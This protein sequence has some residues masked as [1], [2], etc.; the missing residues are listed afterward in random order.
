ME[1]VN[2]DKALFFPTPKELMDK[3]DNFEQCQAVVEAIRDGFKRLRATRENEVL[4][5]VRVDAPKKSRCFRRIVKG[6]E[7]SEWTVKEFTHEK[8]VDVPFTFLTI[9]TRSNSVTFWDK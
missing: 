8:H 5:S 7:A 4:R 1:G 2:N 6:L 9:S 3:D